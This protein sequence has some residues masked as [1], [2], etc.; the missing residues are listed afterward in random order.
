MS[1]NV[2]NRGTGAGG[3]NTNANGLDYE[4]L[5]DLSD[6]FDKQCSLQNQTVKPKQLHHYKE[7]TFQNY[8]IALISAHQSRFHKAMKE[9]NFPML[10]DIDRGIKGPAHGCKNPDEAY[11]HLPTKTIFIIEKKF[12][13]CSGSVC[14]KIQAASFKRRHYQKLYPQF[15]IHYI[16]CLSEWFKTNCPAELIDLQEEQ[17]IPIFFG[18]D[19]KYKDNIIDFIHQT[20]NTELA[21]SE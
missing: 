13:Q 10:L 16:F 15:T 3:A 12:Q 4:S 20:I 1:S 5:T 2:T 11:I 9:L 18:N 21:H 6:M 7:I 8:N 19:E 17:H 14:E